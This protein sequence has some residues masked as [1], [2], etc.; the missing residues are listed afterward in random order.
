MVQRRPGPVLGRRLAHGFVIERRGAAAFEVAF[1]ESDL[2]EDGAHA[3]QVALFA[4]MTGAQQR[5]LVAREA[6]ARRAVRQDEGQGLEGLERRARKSRVVRIAC[7]PQQA[8]VEVDHGDRTGVHVFD[9]IA[10]IGIAAR[11]R[12]EG[13]WLHASGQWKR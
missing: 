8:A 6:E 12:G 4:G 10:G 5:E 11:G 7:L 9:D 1:V 2:A 3:C 13:D